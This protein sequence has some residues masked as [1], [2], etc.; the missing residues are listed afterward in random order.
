MRG[1][2]R[3][4]WTARLDE[5]FRTCPGVVGYALRHRDERRQLSRLAR[6]LRR[7][8][9]LDRGWHCREGWAW[10]KQREAAWFALVGRHRF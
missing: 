4:K 1:D 5:A 3:K 7:R 6:E 9:V 10:S 2:F 8:Q